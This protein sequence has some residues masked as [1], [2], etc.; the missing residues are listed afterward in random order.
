MNVIKKDELPAQGSGR[1]TLLHQGKYPWIEKRRFAVVG[2]STIKTGSVPF[3]N[4][5]LTT[6][7]F[8]GSYQESGQQRK[9]NTHNVLLTRSEQVSSPS[10]AEQL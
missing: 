6:T 10:L 1:S 8:F 4:F 9:R 2:P 3:I 5:L 7:L